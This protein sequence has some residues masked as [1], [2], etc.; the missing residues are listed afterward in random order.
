MFFGW[1]I[2]HLN[3]FFPPSWEYR[4]LFMPTFSGTQLGYKTRPWCILESQLQVSSSD[5]HH[6]VPRS[7]LNMSERM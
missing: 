2:F 1:F 7:T 3:P 6:C 4:F 5:M